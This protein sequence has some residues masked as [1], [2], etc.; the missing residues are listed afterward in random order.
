M[1]PIRIKLEHAE[2]DQIVQYCIGAAGIARLPE[3]SLELVVLAEF[4]DKIVTKLMQ[5]RN[6]NRQKVFTYSI[7]ISVARILHRR[8]QDIP[9]DKDRQMVMSAIDYELTRLNLKPDPKKPMIV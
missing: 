8:W 9:Y 1:E 7:P 2:A 5:N 3:A 4:R 6:K